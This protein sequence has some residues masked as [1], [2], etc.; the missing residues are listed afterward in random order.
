[1][2]QPQRPS[3]PGGNHNRPLGGD[4]GPATRPGNPQPDTRQLP[5]DPDD[6]V[7]GR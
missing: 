7:R 2:T 4:A 6:Y 5:R 3:D 1:M